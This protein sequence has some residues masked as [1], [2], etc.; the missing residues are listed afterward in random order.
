VE[1]TSQAKEILEEL[2]NDRSLRF[3]QLV[4]RGYD[5]SYVSRASLEL[6]EKGL[7]EVSEETQEYYLS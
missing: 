6:E 2:K 5:Q 3:E 1:L 4:E 7:A